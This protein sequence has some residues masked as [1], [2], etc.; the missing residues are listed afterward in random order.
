MESEALQGYREGFY[1]L[2]RG[3]GCEADFTG[4]GPFS[5]GADVSPSGHHARC[6]RRYIAEGVE[7]EEQFSVLKEL[8]CNV[9]PGYLFGRPAPAEEIEP[10]FGRTL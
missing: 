1:N 5:T 10:L 4:T 3:P 2:T 9:I 7:T 6:V 8:G